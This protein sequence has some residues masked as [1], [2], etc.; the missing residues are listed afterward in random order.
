MSP[1]R[2]GEEPPLVCRN[3]GIEVKCRRDVAMLIG[4]GRVLAEPIMRGES[5]HRQGRDVDWRAMD[6]ALR[7]IVRL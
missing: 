7:T 3:H 1:N 4:M 6:E 5:S 2:G